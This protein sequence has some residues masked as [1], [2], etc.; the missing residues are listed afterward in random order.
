VLRL[1]ALCGAV[2]CTSLAA[3][4]PAGAVTKIPLQ[5][6]YAVLDLPK[7]G[8]LNV[9]TP[10]HPLLVNATIT[11]LTSTGATF[12]VQ[13]SDWNFPTYSFSTPAPGT[14]NVT[15]SKPASGSVDFATGAVSLQA[16]LLS[17]V[18]LT[19]IGDCKVDTGNLNMS[20]ATTE[21][22]LGQAFPTGATGVETGNGALGAG[23]QTLPSG[24]GAGCALLS[25]Y[26]S[27]VGGLW[28]SGNLP[29]ATLKAGLVK[30]KAVKAGKTRKIKA[31]FKN[32]GGTSTGQV[33]ACL[34]AP[35]GFKKPLNVCK[36]VTNVPAG[37]TVTV[38]FKVKP[39]K[40]KTKKYTLKLTAIPAATGL[41]KA[42]SSTDP[43]GALTA[44][45]TLKVLK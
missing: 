34:K 10:A 29:P 32:S 11:G 4:A 39:L 40:K 8:A 3:A 41:R 25:G 35:K 15:L 21:P 7:T 1:L 17:D 27:G 30:P 22:L 36:M 18:T 9:V 33:K 20:T 45:T 26:L 5:F 13:K 43:T 44:S 31:T 28:M 2:A 24:S 6:K 12:V 42:Q 14:I 37:K 23:W 16:D 38:I 19:G